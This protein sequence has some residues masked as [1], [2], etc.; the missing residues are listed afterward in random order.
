MRL[1][2]FEEWQL[3]QPSTPRAVLDELARQ[4]SGAEIDRVDRVLE[5]Y[6]NEVYRVRCTSGSDIVIRILRFDD[7]VS[8]SRSVDEAWAIEEARRAGVPTGE[9][10]LLSSVHLDGA[11]YPVMVQRAVPGVPLS[12]VITEL[13]LKQR[14]AVLEEVG[15]L[16]GRLGSVAVDRPSEW[17]ANPAV[18]LDLLGK[19]HAPILGAAATDQVRELFVQ[20][21]RYLADVAVHP[22]VLSHGDLSTKHIFVVSDGP[23][24][25][26]QVSG[27][28][29]FGDWAPA[30]TLHDL[31]VLRVRS[32]ELEVQPMLA[33]Y[34]GIRSG[35]RR[36][37]LDLHTLVIAVDALTF[38]VAE[39]DH[40][41][42][43]VT[44]DLIR[45]LVQDLTGPTH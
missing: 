28:I 23:V 14:S 7:D 26:A 6:S 5:G 8:M 37:E 40:A 35:I 20:L 42:T 16:I 43:G 30:P 34:G 32:P 22:M 13:S 25:G 36:R 44:A 29:D 12:Q 3:S 11:E 27:F 39:Q 45:T 2:T 10:L 41:S 19:D 1:G 33:G 15:R 21:D 4:A 24:A 38:Q 17:T 9:V 18:R 31:A